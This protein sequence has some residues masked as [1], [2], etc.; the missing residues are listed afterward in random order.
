MHKP[1]T[2]TASRPP[3]TQHRGVAVQAFSTYSAGF[4]FD[5]EEQWLPFSSSI[6]NTHG[7]EYTERVRVKQLGLMVKGFQNDF[8]S[9]PP[10]F[11]VFGDAGVHPGTR[12]TFLSGKV[13]K[14]MLAEA[15]PF[16]FPARFADSFGL[17]Q[18]RSGG[19]QTRGVCP[20]P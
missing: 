17:A 7:R 11:M 8:S 9:D 10:H 1:F 2:Q 19:T 12:S 5:A 14:T 18:D 16:G 15:W 3:S 13:A 20:E 6:S 4:R